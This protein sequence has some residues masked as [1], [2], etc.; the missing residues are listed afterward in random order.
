MMKKTFSAVSWL[1]V[2]ALW[3]SA[4]SVYVSPAVWGKFF[5][6]PGLAFPFC[7]AAVLACLALG[8]VARTR[9]VFIPLLGL[10]GCCG[11]LRD[12]C[13]LN[14]SSPHPKG[15]IKV[16]SYN[17]MGW[18]KLKKDEDS[19]FSVARFIC[20]QRPDIACLQ[21]AT[22]FHQSD[23]AAVA[24]T[25]R[26]H[27]YHLVVNKVKE[28]FFA[29]ATRYPVV[30]SEQVCHSRSNGA[31]AY[32]LVPEKGD[33]LLVIN[34]HLQTM[35]LTAGE[36][37]T[38]REMVKEPERADTVKGKRVLLGKIARAGVERALQADTLAAYID[39]HRGGKLILMGD[40][41]DTP[42]SY[43]HHAACA[44]LTDAFRATGNGIGRSF[45]RDAMVIRIDNIFCSSHWKPFAARVDD[46]VP[47]SD[48]YPVTAYLKPVK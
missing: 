7:A 28:T 13:P 19:T 42:V 8:L 14:V 43:A 47:F 9:L 17:T 32:F 39:R 48:H 20:S 1:C 29:L 15:C 12:Y 38:Y 41:N 25:F 36:R 37:S 35:S 30:R 34:A 5:S 24:A 31:F 4:A 6:L 11:T 23:S 27:G 44:R 33:T 2:L 21:E 16:M 18:G 10:L 46:T 22:L 40:F 26:R 3:G 45:N